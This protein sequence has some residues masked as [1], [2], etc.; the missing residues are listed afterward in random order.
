MNARPSAENQ[1]IAVH[2]AVDTDGQRI[3]VH[4]NL[5]PAGIC[6]T[7]RQFFGER[8]AP[9]LDDR[10]D[11]ESGVLMAIVCSRHKLLAISR[12][13]SQGIGNAVDKEWSIYS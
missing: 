5:K 3:T 12:E 7:A 9:S 11:P 4:T 6:L 13:R 10:F 8:R 1:V 2:D